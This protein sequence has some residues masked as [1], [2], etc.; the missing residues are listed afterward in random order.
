MKIVTSLSFRGQCREAFEFYAKLLGGKITAAVPYSAMPEA[1][2]FDPKYKDWLMHCW[3]DVGDQSLMGADMDI[4]WAPNI[5]KP[6]NGFDATLHTDDADQARRWFEQLSEGGKTTMPFGPTFWS[7]AF[8]ACVDRFG[9]P[10]MVNTVPP[11]D[12]QGPK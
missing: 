12:W 4:Q 11:A 6:K 2:G 1:E 10:W 8:G 9:I 3:L 5:D 7:P